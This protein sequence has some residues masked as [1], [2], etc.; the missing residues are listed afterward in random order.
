MILGEALIHDNYISGLGAYNAG[1]NIQV[2]AGA[3]DQ[4]DN[5]QI[6]DNVIHTP[7]NSADIY[8]ASGLTNA[9]KR[10][11][12]NVERD[13]RATGISPSNVY[14]QEVA[15]D[16]L[17]ADYVA[18][19]QE[20][21][22]GG[23]ASIDGTITATGTGGTVI[24]AYSSDTRAMLRFDSGAGN[25]RWIG[26]DDDSNFN[27]WN[28]TASIKQLTVQDNGN[29]GIGTSLPAAKMHVTGRQI[30]A[31]GINNASFFQD[32]PELLLE[33]DD[34]AGLQFS[35]PSDRSNYIIFG[36]DSNG[37]AGQIVYSHSSDSLGFYNGGDTSL[38]MIIDG[39]QNV[40]IGTP[41][42]LRPLHVKSSTGWGYI[43]VEGAANQGAQVQFRN[44]A[45]DWKIGVQHDDKFRIRDDTALADR[46]MIDT[47]GNVGIGT[48]AP[49]RKLHVSDAMRL[50]PLAAQPSSGALGDIYMDT[51]GDLHIYRTNGWHTVSVSKD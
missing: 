11:N 14:N 20:L 29:V 6:F 43:E 33:D 17:T 15:L 26:A 36:D 31:E 5:I 9:V 18:I 32:I 51:N 4:F 3:E 2:S 27:V 42:P 48:S 40:G 13:G 39:N 12:G 16:S 38:A 37:R 34:N 45:R 28:S 8:L 30:I 50:E 47:S 49:A 25:P 23:N 10:I 22:V 21:N 24:E 46:M 41:S 44:D 7:L 19:N 35:S 1:I